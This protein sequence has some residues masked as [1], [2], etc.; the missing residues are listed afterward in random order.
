MLDRE[1]RQAQVVAQTPYQAAWEPGGDRLAYLD[2]DDLRTIHILT[3][4][5][6]GWQE[7][8]IKS[9]QSLQGFAWRPAGE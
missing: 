1:G 7:R 6:T 5:N 4:A 2:A 3:P 8:T 9:T